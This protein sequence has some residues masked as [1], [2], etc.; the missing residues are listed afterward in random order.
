MRLGLSR[1]SASA[2]A[3]SFGGFRVPSEIVKAAAVLAV[4]LLISGCARKR[5]WQEVLS[6]FRVVSPAVAY[7]ILRDNPE[8]PVIDLRPSEDVQSSGSI[9]RAVNIPVESL[10]GRLGD[11]A[12]VLRSGLLIYCGDDVCGEPALSILRE[13]GFRYVF[14]LNGGIQAWK[15]QGFELVP[16]S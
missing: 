6:G 11:F 9:Q 1:R 4:A 7:E 3:A 8:L 2:A 13:N 14:I 10:A 16:P 15:D 12:G 5:P